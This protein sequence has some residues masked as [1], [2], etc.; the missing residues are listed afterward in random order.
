MRLETTNNRIK[1]IA[2][3]KMFL[4]AFMLLIC[5][6]STVKANTFT[7]TNTNDGGAGSL[8]QAIIDANNNPGKDTI[9]FDISGTGPYTIQPT[10]PL[11]DI[12]D[13]VVIDGLS[14]SGASC[15]KWPPRLMIEL[16][17][18]LTGGGSGLAIIGGR[19][20][21]KGLV[22]NRFA[23]SAI[24]INSNGNNAVECNFIGTDVTG[25]SDLG[26]A[27]HGVIISGTSGN[28]IGGKKIKT[29]NLISG[30]GGSGISIGVEIRMLVDGK[31][32]AGYHSIRWDGKDN[33]GQPVTS[34]L[35]LY[36]L[37]AGDFSQVKKMNLVR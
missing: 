36:R 35:Y 27:G 21:V 11:P 6:V 26:N 29:R 8:R 5:A 33:M 14:Q 30:N 22:I 32:E 2:A 28:I 19:S 24:E 13:P 4:A 17:G 12:T 25:N 7:V 3:I 10:S 15:K 1:R 20:T 16:D 9:V 23:G 18:S 37:Q 34:G 31:Y